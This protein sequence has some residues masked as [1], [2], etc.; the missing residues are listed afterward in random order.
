MTAPICDRHFAERADAKAAALAQRAAGHPTAYARRC[1]RCAGWRL[2]Y[3]GQQGVSKPP[4][5][6]Q[7][8]WYRVYKHR[9]SLRLERCRWPGCDRRDDLTFDHIVPWSVR[10]SWKFD[11]TTILCR[12]HN[13]EKGDQ[14]DPTGVLISLAAEEAAAAPKQ[15]WS[16]VGVRLYGLPPR[17]RSRGRAT[18]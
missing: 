17:R 11:N 6:W 9:I 4:L 3:R 14:P 12:P 10:P 2:S 15:R 7:T 18:A 8:T 1:S 13:V 16:Q 5:S